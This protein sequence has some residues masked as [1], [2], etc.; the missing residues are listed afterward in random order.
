MYNIATIWIFCSITMDWSLRV[1]LYYSTIEDQVLIF[2]SCL[3]LAII[4]M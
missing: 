3:H 1:Y 2:G 4:K